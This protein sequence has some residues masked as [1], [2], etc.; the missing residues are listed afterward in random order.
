MLEK[1]F[2]ALWQK[3]SVRHPHPFLQGMYLNFGGFSTFWSEPAGCLDAFFSLIIMLFAVAFNGFD[4]REF[5]SV[6]FLEGFVEFP[7][8]GLALQLL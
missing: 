3:E 1:L 2:H 7:A 5:F 8:F 6:C 4:L